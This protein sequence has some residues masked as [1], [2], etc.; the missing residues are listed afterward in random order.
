MSAGVG[1]TIAELKARSGLTWGEL[2]EA[3][4]ASSGDYVRK[5]ASGAKPGR[6]LA[7]AVGQLMT[8]GRVTDTPARRLTAA[9]D[10]AR[11]RAPRSSGAP[12]RVPD[13]KAPRPVPRRLFDIGTGRLGWAKDISAA[14]PDTIRAAVRS[15][16]RGRR[17]VSLRVGYRDSRGKL[18]Y[19]VI[20]TK[21][22]YKAS[23]VLSAMN[24]Q[25]ADEWIHDQ[26]TKAA[27][28][29]GSFT[30]GEIETVEVYAQ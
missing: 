14:D 17:R 16:A 1:A 25:G 3:I 27:H 13:V 12:S 20:G 19:A 7:G 24:D 6:N 11:V 18:R 15:A 29:G 2:A 4:G 8:T 26:L 21:N 23:G 10:L 22:G 9:G 5:V 30:A 28:N